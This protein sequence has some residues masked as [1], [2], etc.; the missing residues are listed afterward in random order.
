MS[1]GSLDG[2]ALETLQQIAG[3][4]HDTHRASLHAFALINQTCHR[5]A[6]PEIF[7][8]IHLTA[9]SRQA[10]QRD[11]DTLRVILSRTGSARHV[12]HLSIEGLLRLD[13]EGLGQSGSETRVLDHESQEMGWSTTTGIGEILP[14][15]EQILAMRHVRR[16]GPVIE[17]ASKEDM[18]WEPFV[19]LIKALPHLNTLLYDCG[20]QFPPSLLD[21]LREHHP[22]CKLHHLTFRLRSLLSDIPDPYE[23]ALATSPC[24]YS[25]KVI[26]SKRDSVGGD[27]FNQKAVTELVTGLAPNLKEIVVVAMRPGLSK[28]FG[29]PPTRWTH[30]PG[31][32]PGAGIG[33]LTSLSIVGSVL[34]SPEL[35]RSWAKHTDFGNLRRLVLGGGWSGRSGFRHGINDEMVGWIVQNCSFPRLRTLRICLERDDMFIERPNYADIVIALFSTLQP[36]EE[37]SVYGPLESEILDAILS[38]HGPTLKSLDLRPNEDPLNITGF[39]DRR[40]IPMVLGKEHVLQIQ[41]HCPAL[42]KLAIPV[43]RTKS[44]AAEA[45]LYKSFGEMIRLQHLFLTLD[46]SEWRVSRDSTYNPSFDEEDK[47][48]LGFSGWLKKGHLRGAFMNCAVDETLARSIWKTICQYKTGRQLQSLKLWT[49]GGGRFGRTT[50]N[51]DYLKV[52]DNLSRSWLI[53]PDVGEMINIREL[54]RRAREMRDQELKDEV[55][56]GSDIKGSQALQVFRRIWPSKEGS[57]DWRHDWSSLPL[58]F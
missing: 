20:N 12:R 26:C 10:L 14:D 47:K 56:P 11:V 31:F 43:K 17:R 30:L 34:W 51:E 1:R 58:Q 2:L 44:D 52:V 39:R 25:I 35:L 4:L 33:S 7:R 37:L 50:N 32:V 48:P 36:L 45:E 13:V 15:E 41:T 38:R 27:E 28:D 57:R 46:C 49:T 54:G 22:R 5:A 16:E 19:R 29:Q 8:E 9:G 55:G 24:L 3:Y 18:A 53:E 6:L 21:A 40:N 23:I 42:E